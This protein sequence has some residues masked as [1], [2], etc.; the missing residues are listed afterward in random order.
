MKQPK[1]VKVD[2]LP[3]WKPEEEGAEIEG[4]IQNLREIET[5]FGK[6]MVCDI[7]EY[8]VG[9]SAGLEPLM[10]LV[11]QYVWLTYQGLQ[12][13]ERT[14]RQFHSFTIEKAEY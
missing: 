14:K 7:G 12:F 1:R 11:G 10:R 8:S 9:I 6:Q 13:N 4:V 3:F 2:R 5:Q